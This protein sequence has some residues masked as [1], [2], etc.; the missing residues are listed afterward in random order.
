MRRGA[1]QGPLTGASRVDGGARARAGHGPARGGEPAA[2]WARARK[3]PRPASNGWG[4]GL[5]LRAPHAA[6]GVQTATRGHGPAGPRPHGAHGRLRL[7]KGG[8]HA[9]GCQ[10]QLCATLPNG[11]P[12][13]GPW[14]PNGAQRS[15][16]NRHFRWAFSDRLLAMVTCQHDTDT[17]GPH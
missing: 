1:L 5:W 13:D 12:T 15:L 16:N 17:V 3:W 7:S 9:V 8:L 10:R 11:S 2:G 14:G 4:G 6:S